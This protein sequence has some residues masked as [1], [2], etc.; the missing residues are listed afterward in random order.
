MSTSRTT[1]RSR[2]MYGGKWRT[3]MRSRTRWSSTSVRSQTWWRSM[4]RRGE[5]MWSGTR[6][7]ATYFSIISVFVLMV[8]MN[9]TYISTSHISH[10]IP[11]IKFRRKV[12]LSYELGNKCLR[13]NMLCQYC[14]ATGTGIGD[15][16]SGLGLTL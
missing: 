2:T 8:I 10:N 13:C 6:R 9:N 15:W 16:D 5:T 7:K 3:V 4:G 11:T 12:C 14:Q 1:M